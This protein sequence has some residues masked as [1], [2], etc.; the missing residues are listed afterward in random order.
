MA[1]KILRCTHKPTFSNHTVRRGVVGRGKGGNVSGEEEKNYIVLVFFLGNR[2]GD[3]YVHKKAW[4]LSCG[5]GR[6]LPLPFFAFPSFVTVPCYTE[7]RLLPFWFP[8][9]YSV[10]PTLTHIHAISYI[11]TH[12]A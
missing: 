7:L 12:T 8:F 2:D 6:Y 5:L 11:L 1:A 9:L 10:L 3:N 4:A